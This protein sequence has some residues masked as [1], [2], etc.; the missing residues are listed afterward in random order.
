MLSGECLV[1][2]TER[3]HRV[4]GRRSWEGWQKLLDDLYRMR[5]GDIGDSDD[6]TLE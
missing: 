3:N 1:E 6:T 2:M 5:C 4:A